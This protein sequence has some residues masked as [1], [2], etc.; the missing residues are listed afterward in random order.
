MSKWW[1][2]ADYFETCNCAHG[3]P[4]NLTMLPTDGTC[5]AVDAWQ[6]RE[7]AA[8]GVRLDGLGIALILNW[9]NPIHKG[10]GR[11]I[12]YV[13]ERANEKQREALGKIGAGKA[14]PGGP[15]E[16]FAGT[17]AEAPQ[18]VYGPFQYERNGRRSRLA[19]GKLAHAD[20]GPIRS[21]MDQSEADAHMV[22]PGGFIWKD[23]VIANTDSCEVDAPGIKF[24]FANT[25]GILSEVTYN[26]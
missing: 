15:F 6:I 18:V 1:W 20:I 23:G 26:V 14:G 3:C 19:L 24:R 21:D 10:N 16:I 4:C 13:D 7:G 9:P 25:N 8:D 22:L 5:K 2:K 11:A 12:V 17:Y